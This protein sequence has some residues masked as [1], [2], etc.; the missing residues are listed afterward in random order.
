MPCELFIATRQESKIR[1]AFANNM[2]KD[3]KLS[4]AQ[5]PEI[6]QSRGFLGKTLG[7]VID[8]L[9]KK[10]LIDLT[11]SLAR[12]V[13]SKIVTKATSS[14]LDKF[15]R[16]INGRR[17]VRAWKGVSLLISSENMDDTIKIVE[18]LEK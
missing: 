18:S 13:L 6:I 7:N 9:G 14:V 10:V 3:L 8:N 17:A 15:E 11:F 16:K 12:D 4:E 5:L 2:L 1:N